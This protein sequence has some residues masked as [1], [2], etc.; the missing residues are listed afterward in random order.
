MLLN[1]KLTLKSQGTMFVERMLH[2]APQAFLVGIAE[3][4]GKESADQVGRTYRISPDMDQNLFITMALRWIG[5]VVFDG[6]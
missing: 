3:Q 5:D 4:L 6:K 1:N 2:V